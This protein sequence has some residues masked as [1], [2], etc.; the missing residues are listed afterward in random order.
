VEQYNRG[1]FERSK[2]YENMEFKRSISMQCSYNFG[3]WLREIRESRSISLRGLGQQAGLNYS[4]IAR[5]EQG[6]H[7]APS[8]ETVICLARAL[9]VPS[10]DALIAAGYMPCDIRYK[11][12]GLIYS[13]S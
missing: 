5:L 12:Y 8:R 2:R 11:A 1:N 7:V 3:L 9:G 10:A 13:G 6:K 4:Y